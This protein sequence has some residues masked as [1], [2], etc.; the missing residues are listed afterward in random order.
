[1]KGN[2]TDFWTLQI[3]QVKSLGKPIFFKHLS[4]HI[5]IANLVK[6]IHIVNESKLREY[7]YEICISDSFGAS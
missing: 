7:D 4:F 5:H 2:D 3:D 1:M 6:I